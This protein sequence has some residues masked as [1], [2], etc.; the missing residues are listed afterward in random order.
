MNIEMLLQKQSQ[1]D[2]VI[3]ENAGIK[4][5]PIA[6]THLALLVEINELAQEVKCFKY[7]KKHKKV[8]RKKVLEE[9]ADCFALALSLENHLGQGNPI[10]YTIAAETFD[11]FN[12]NKCPNDSEKLSLKFTIAIHDTTELKAPLLTILALGTC[13]KISSDEME[14]A[15]LKKNKINLE[16]QANNY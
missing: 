6:E 9:Y 2:K 3:F 10:I 16:R 7:W 5:Y 13:L 4:E 8:D 12:N 15:Y 11:E 1:L 14:Q